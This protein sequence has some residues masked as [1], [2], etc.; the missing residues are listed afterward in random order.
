MKYLI[1]LLIGL[2]AC[3]AQL[4][5]QPDGLH[6]FRLAN[7]E[8][9]LS[10]LA[11]QVK[12]ISPR[13]TSITH[14][15]LLDALIYPTIDR[16]IAPLEIRNF[17]LNQKPLPAGHTLEAV[18][19]GRLYS[20]GSSDGS[21]EGAAL[22]LERRRV[23]RQSLQE[24]LDQTRRDKPSSRPLAAIAAD[25]QARLADPPTAGTSSS[26]WARI[27]AATRETELRSFAAT[28]IENDGPEEG[29]RQQ[30]LSVVEKLLIG[31]LERIPTR[32]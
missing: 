2:N 30:V 6:Q 18:I 7:A 4:E 12:H 5:L 20:D 13:G 10:A 23:A 17:P 24:I 19:V 9:E 15:V 3:W 1:S 29:R 27:L 32:P 14:Y 16:P 11:I 21:Q 22:L 25:L 26:H 31:R 8:R 28:L